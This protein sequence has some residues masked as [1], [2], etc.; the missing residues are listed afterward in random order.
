MKGY[1]AEEDAKAGNN[2]GKTTLRENLGNVFLFFS[3][4]WRCFLSLKVASKN[5]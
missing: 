1:M 4:I 5:T 2:M 3:Q